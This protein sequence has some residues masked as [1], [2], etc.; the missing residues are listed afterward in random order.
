MSLILSTILLAVAAV[1]PDRTSWMTPAAFHLTVGMPRADAIEALRAWNPK[2]GTSPD[3]TVVDYGDDKAITLVFRRDRVQSIR[4]ELFVLLPDSRKAFDEARSFVHAAHG[5]PRRT[6]RSV[7]VWDQTLPNVILAV[8]DDPGSPQGRK[9]LGVVAVRY[10]D[11][12]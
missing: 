10:Y 9:G 7:L 4:F 12:R 11:P 8:A 2:P 3:E 6:G 1:Q 5:E